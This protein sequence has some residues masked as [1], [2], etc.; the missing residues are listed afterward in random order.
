M[1]ALMS[2]LTAFVQQHSWHTESNLC[3][4]E[5]V[6]PIETY[7]KKSPPMMES[8]PMELTSVCRADSS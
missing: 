1:K 2:K 3:M 6:F 7:E 8:R 5:Q 4:Q